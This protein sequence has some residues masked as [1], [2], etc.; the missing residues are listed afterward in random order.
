[1]AW[2]YK[3]LVTL[4]ASLVESEVHTDFPVLVSSTYDGT[5]GEPDLRTTGNGGNVENANGYDIG[6]F[7]DFGLTTRLAAER[8][9][10]DATTGEVE[11]WV[12]IPSLSN[13]SNTKIYMAYGDSSVS[14]D[15]NDDVTYG[16]TSVWNSG[17]SGRYHFGDGTTLSLNDSTS[18]GR[19]M[20]GIGIPTAATGKAGKGAIQLNGTSQFA[21]FTTKEHSSAYTY[22]FWVKGDAAPSNSKTSN[23]FQIGNEPA[24][25]STNAACQWDELGGDLGRYIHRKSDASFETAL[26]T[27]TFSGLIKGK[28]A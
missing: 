18:D 12:K 15:P 14:S 25:N 1:M 21:T 20:T 10:F 7:S 23:I 3:A 28:L 9:F 13:V 22:S 19:D 4:N 6:F 5:G 27:S 11:F 24:G 8:V 17:F 26:P 16:S 2:T